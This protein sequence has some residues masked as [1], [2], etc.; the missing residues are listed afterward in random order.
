[1]KNARKQWKVLQNNLLIE[2]ELVILLLEAD[3]IPSDH[4]CEI[5]FLLK[6]KLKNTII[7]AQI[8]NQFNEFTWYIN[9]ISQK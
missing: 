8:V 5:S 3:E 1:V 9:S 4:M 6:L 2:D 7:L